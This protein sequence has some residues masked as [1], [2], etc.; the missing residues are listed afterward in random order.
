MYQQGT[1]CESPKYSNNKAVI[2]T[3][4]C[5][6]LKWQKGHAFLKR[7]YLFDSGKK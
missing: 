2:G 4:K 7:L 5:I 1:N 3:S 6:T